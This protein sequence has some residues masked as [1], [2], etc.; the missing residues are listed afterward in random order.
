MFARHTLSRRQFVGAAAASV[1]L[2]GSAFGQAAKNVKILLPNSAILLSWAPSYLAEAL[3]YYKDEGLAVERIATNG[4]PAGLTAL[5]AGS[6]PLVLTPPGELLAAAA[7]GQ[8]LKTLMPQ[9]NNLGFTFVISKDYAARH[10][11]TADATLEQRRAVLKNFKGIRCGVTGAGGTIDLA[12]RIMLSDSGLDASVDANMLPLGSSASFLAGLSNNTLDGFMAST[13]VPEFAI[14]Q[15]GA[16]QLFSVAKSEIRVLNGLVGH[17][18]EARS[19]D[20]E[21]DPDLYTAFIRADVRATRYIVEKPSEAADAL[22]QAR[23]S[24][25]VN[26]D[27][28]STIWNNNLSLFRTPY[29]TKENL[30]LWV[31]VGLVTGVSDPAAIKFDEV[32]DMRFVDSAVK[33]IGWKIPA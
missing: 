33:K 29:I 8:R 22:Y 32:V 15:L 23:F 21:R 4:G 26:R 30:E 5:L 17:V 14:S 27:L 18:T 28:W 11:I 1:V 31:K 9:A 13:P 25:I 3:G 12:T 20:V 24:S 6:G 10:N 7:K 2:P 19:V 16:V